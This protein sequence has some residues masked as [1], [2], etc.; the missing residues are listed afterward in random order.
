MADRKATIS[1]VA[2]AAGVSIATVS[3]VMRGK[4]SVTP[5]LADRVRAAAERLGYLPSPVARGLAMGYSRMV[6]VLV[7]QLGNPYFQGMVKAIAMGAAEDG[8]RMLVSET[9][10]HPEDE[11]Q[12]A[13]GLYSHADGVILCSPRMPDEQ[14][15]D[16][17]ADRSRL[18]C[19]NRIPSG[20]GIAALAFDSFSAMLEVC[21]LLGR[22]G[23][24]RVVFLSGPGASWINAERRRA[25][26]A[27]SEFG[28]EPIIEPGGYR[29]ADGYA[30]TDAALAHEPTAILAGNDLAAVGVLSRLRERKIRVPEDI[31]VTGFDDIPFTQ[32]TIPTITTV[33]SPRT[34]LG[35]EAWNML[36]RIMG[37]EVVAA[38]PP[39]LKPELMVRD[40]TGPA[41]KE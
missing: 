17:A 28:I 40:S 30:S 7:P 25:L 19:T 10:D 4:E 12:I 34:E 2:K 9:D 31:S 18:V 3:R 11:F 16:L 39:M 27:A 15:R 29:I 41:R 23:H 33:R 36:H 22:L 14:L 5:A 13:Q 6:G 38:T 1:D 8:Y 35:V 21:G 26:G 24:R 20:V 32:H 37:G